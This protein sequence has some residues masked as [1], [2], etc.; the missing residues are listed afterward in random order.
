[1]DNGGNDKNL[2]QKIADL[3]REAATLRAA[4]LVLQDTEARFRRHLE[5]PGLLFL[6]LDINGC[7]ADAN[8]SGLKL[9]GYGRDELIGKNWFTTCLPRKDQ[10]P[11]FNHYKKL[12]SGEVAPDDYFEN[13]IL[14]KDGTERILGWNN[15]LTH[16]P[17]GE[18]NGTFSSGE[19]IS[20]RRAAERRLRDAYEIINKSP[21]VTF[22]WRNEED[23]PVDF[24]SEN[25]LKLLGYTTAEFTSGSI[26]Y[27]KTIHPDDLA[28]VGQ[29]VAEFSTDAR[30]TEFAHEPYR[31]ICKDGQTKW[32][33]DQTSARKDEDGTITHFQGIVIDITARKKAQ[34]DLEKEKNELQMALN[35]VK[36]LSG[37]LPI[38]AS[39]KKIR[40]DKGYWNQ[41]ESYVR[42]H[43]EAEFT[44]GICPEC[45]DRLYPELS[46]ET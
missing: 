11:V 43:S 23:W 29:E 12:M 46:D 7:I 1:M 40:D 26:S 20:A 16:N 8:E 10:V 44:H 28:R 3:D 9:L 6:T 5:L 22:L 36:T 35:K 13:S 17:A 33:D 21:A 34:E 2:L 14:H 32:L 19:D 25:V 41:I 24:V 15:A 31:V 39:C 45:S 18:I 37:M 38:C 30:L 4:N 42:D 27:A